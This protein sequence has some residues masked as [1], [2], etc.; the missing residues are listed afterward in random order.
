MGPPT[1]LLWIVGDYALRWREFVGAG[2]FGVL[3]VPV[4]A[5]L[6]QAPNGPPLRRG[7]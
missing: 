5:R 1:A 4:V 2:R 7:T 6:R 3:Q